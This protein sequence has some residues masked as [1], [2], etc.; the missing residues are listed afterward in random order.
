[1]GE[2]IQDVIEEAVENFRRQRMFELHNQ[3]YA[4]LK[5]DPERWKQELEERRVWDGAV[6]DGL[7]GV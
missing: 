3:A 7:E 6:A 1:M 5:A 4:A 2:P